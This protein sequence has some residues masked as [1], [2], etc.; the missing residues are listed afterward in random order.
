MISSRL[1]NINDRSWTEINLD[2]FAYNLEQIKAHFLPHQSFIQIV[3]ADAY[4][5]GAVQIAKKAIECG[6]VMLGVANAEEGVLLR[7]QNIKADILILSPSLESEID[8]IFEYN[9]IP[10]VSNL[11]FANKLNKY[12]ADRNTKFKI[13][14][15]CDTGMNRNGV[16]VNDISGFIEAVSQLDNLIIDGLFSHFSASENDDE[17][18]HQQYTLFTEALE[19][20]KTDI[21][22]IHIAN[23]SAVV[24]YRFYETNL[25]RL[26]LLSYGIYTDDSIKSLVNL[27]PV[28]QFKSKVSHISTAFPDETIGYNRLF[29]VKKITKYAII[30]VGYADGYDFLLSDKA[31]VSINNQDCDVLGKISMDMLAVDISKLDDVRLGDEVCLLGH[32]SKYIRA[33][34]LA[35][36]YHGSSYELLCQIGRRARRYYIENAVINDSAPILRRDFIP[37]DFSDD[38][39]NKIIHQ[40]I[41]ERI[42]KKELASVI[43]HDI[44]KYFFI[45]SDRDVS[46]RSDFVHSIQFNNHHD[47]NYKDY[48]KVHA[49][50][51]YTKVLQN[52]SF[53]VACANDQKTLETYF[54]RRDTEYRWLLDENIVINEN[55]FQIKSARIDN[56]ELNT[57][58]VF[59]DNCIEFLCS[60]DSLKALIGQTVNFYIDTITYYPKKSHQLS[61]Y[62]TEITKGIELNFSYPD[63]I[64]TVETVPIFSGKNKYPNIEYNQNTIK[65]SSHKNEWIFPN[66]GVVFSY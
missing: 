14:I 18:T 36:L 55:A 26:G 20:I 60:S 43:Y 49:S 19:N 37:K 11:S 54:K 7:F 13:H 22:Y 6:A 62:L 2:N 28:M 65:L 24:K 57:L 30:P 45:D 66:S 1:I 17:F 59:N 32:K 12:C 9:L 41:E 44:L 16:R 25:L 61:I 4:G 40:A 53:I 42:Q 46:Y 31:S 27:K 58:A 52:D 21:H 51:S 33:E 35:S 64:K 48:Y 29:K 47:P 3:K 10:S 50:I 56:I 5:H 15:K 23:S 34:Y 39:L 63:N 38:K 8:T